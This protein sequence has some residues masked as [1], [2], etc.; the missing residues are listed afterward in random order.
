MSRGYDGSLLSRKGEVLLTRLGVTV[1]F[2]S[3]VEE[4]LLQMLDVDGGVVSVERAESV[5][6]YTSDGASHTYTPDFTVTFTDGRVL[7][8]ECKPRKLLPLLLQ[9]NADAW[10]ARVTRLE[11]LGR[12]LYVVTERDLPRERVQQAIT[13][14][15]FHG[16]E[17]SAELGE[18]ARKTLRERG[19]LPLVTLRLLLKEVAPRLSAHLDATLLSMLA[20]RE[21]VA[22]VTALPPTCLVDLPGRSIPLPPSPVGWP[23][24]ALL[25]E[26]LEQVLTPD[27]STDQGGELRLEAQFL[28][29]E[30]GQRALQLFALYSDPT[31]PLDNEQA[32]ELG[33]RVG[34]S[35]RTVYRFREALVEA[36]APG[37]TFTE[38]VPYLARP[39]QGKPRRQVEARVTA[40]MERLAREHYFVPV[41]TAGR[42][43]TVSNLSELVR[44][45]CLAEELPPP[46]YNTV[47]RFAD[48]LWEQDPVQATLLR[49][50]R[51]KAQALEP[52][53][54]HLEVRRYGELLGV[55]CTPCDVFTREEGLTVVPLREGRGKRQRHPEAR[56]G[57]IINIVD[58]VTSQ[59]L[60]SVVVVKPISAALV[61]RVL[62]DLFLGDT[63]EL[64][65]AGVVTV[66]QAMGL[67][68]RLRLDGGSEFINRQVKRVLAHLGITVLPRN[69]WSRHHGGIEER[70]IGITTHYQHILP[71]T[72]MN[73]IANRGKYD[74]QRGAVLTIADLNRY[75]QRIVE[76]HNN[77]C[78]P[79]RE[80]TRHEHAQHL[81][82]QGLTA[83]RP[84]STT[85]LEFLRN[86]M[87]PQ[88]I[89]KCGQEG[90]K[91]LGLIY[92]AP[93]LDPLIVRGAS[94][95]VLY[96]PD[97]IS[98]ARAVHPDTGALIHLQARLP[99]GVEGPLSLQEWV[100]I[101][102]RFRAARQ[103]ALDRV[104]TPQQLLAEVMVERQ[105]RLQ[106]GK[107]KAPATSLTSL[108]P[109]PVERPG[110][111]P[112]IQPAEI[113]F[114]E[115]PPGG[116]K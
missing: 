23:L 107:Q 50:G 99:E 36:G 10:Q 18:L 111:R 91:L 30:R 56:R 64:V 12:P 37:I 112:S 101:K 98:T 88:E 27:E 8:L 57:N 72:T 46:A 9:E 48:R 5:T 28:R 16:V 52:R 71:G 95:E 90:I 32:E 19:A 22:D 41:G 58:V 67:P 39:G 11:G 103:S 79:L 43:A 47:R 6:V 17:G 63:S 108:K 105:E 96:N 93:E 4:R 62:R 45:A 35:G 78:A 86:R 102:G 54:G 53:Q 82:D 114:E 70:T 55:D 68:Q 44:K 26:S 80:L 109:P 113:V 40:I 75:H 3:T 85:Q 61:L 49:E 106:Q 2:E 110:T 7:S 25:R 84:P 21:L 87:H 73:N 42:T 1:R 59:V 92:N 77:L 89:K 24:R 104:K 76:R 51:E 33:Q 97:D 15:P 14:G 74:A 81:L 100:E 38:L 60:R 20:R 31:R 13:F 116:L 66:P 83:W 69:Q 94:V 29:T 34:V 65:A 115:N